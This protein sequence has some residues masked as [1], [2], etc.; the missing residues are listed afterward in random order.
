MSR[1]IFVLSAFLLSS[2]FSML[3]NAA[4]ITF[5]DKAVFEA[6]LVTSTTDDYSAIAYQSGDLLD[7]PNLDRHSNAQMSSIFGETDYAP[8]G[9]DILQNNL[10][11]N[12][13]TNPFY[14]AGC[15]GSFMLSFLSTSFGSNSG[16]YGVG[17]DFYN[18]LSDVQYH[19]FVTFGDLTTQDILLDVSSGPPE[20]FFGI[21]SDALIRS[22]DLGL[23]NGGTTTSG[24]FGIDNLTIGSNGASGANGGG[25]D[26]ASVPAPTTF[27][28]FGIGLAVLG[29]SKRTK[30]QNPKS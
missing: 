22:I 3:G 13:T 5:D 11:V 8:T 1:N 17:F 6:A 14:C 27:A 24:S 23:A 20:D 9:F 19:A 2:I 25:S 26:S 7:N 30:A 12:Q 4:Y 10:I 21:T 18:A 29:C 15:N 28:L 16:V